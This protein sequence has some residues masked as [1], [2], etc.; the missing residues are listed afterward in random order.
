MCNGYK[1]N[2]KFGLY[3]EHLNKVIAYTSKTTDR[4]TIQGKVNLFSKANLKK[5]TIDRFA[6]SCQNTFKSNFTMNVYRCDTN[7]KHGSKYK[8]Y[9]W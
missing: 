3:L 6:S 1:L 8:R 4:A 9:I 2:D 7:S 5:C